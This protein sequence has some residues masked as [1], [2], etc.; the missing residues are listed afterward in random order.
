[1]GLSESDL[2]ELPL[3]FRTASVTD[4]P[5]VV[6]LVESAYRGDASRKGWTT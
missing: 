6:A 4:I 3:A 2:V 1:M 5:A